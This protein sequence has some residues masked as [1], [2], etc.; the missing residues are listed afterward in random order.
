MIQVGGDGIKHTHEL[1][2]AMVD[3]VL[4]CSP[5]LS[6]SDAQNLLSKL[7]N[8]NND[9]YSKVTIVGNVRYSV[10]YAKNGDACLYIS[11]KK[12]NKDNILQELGDSSKG[13]KK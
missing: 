12:E 13:S 3:A 6:P 7:I 8:K 10:G 1:V 11:H 9:Q 2:S 5:E 4:A